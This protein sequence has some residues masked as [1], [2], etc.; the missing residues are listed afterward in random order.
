MI[1]KNETM[2]LKQL[3]IS[4]F[5]CLEGLAFQY[6][7]KLCN[8]TF[9]NMIN[10]DDVMYSNDEYLIAINQ[11]LES[12]II[13]KI[14]S[15]PFYSIMLDETTDFSKSEQLAIYISFLDVQDNKIKSVFFK[16]A[17]IPDQFGSTIYKTSKSFLAKQNLDLKKLIGFTSDNASNMVGYKLGVYSY[18]LLDIAYILLNRCLN[19]K[20][21]LQGSRLTPNQKIKCKS[22]Y[23]KIR[24]FKFIGFT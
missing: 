20:I 15:S 17:S 3:E 1:N 14:K 16:I 5:V 23:D 8:L 10:P 11:Y 18:F 7:V 6:F 13:R 2:V 12:L 9:G 22:I 21:Q 19:H 4:Y 24:T